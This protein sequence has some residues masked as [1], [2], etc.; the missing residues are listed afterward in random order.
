MKSDVATFIVTALVKQ[1]AAEG[2]HAD[3]MAQ[4]VASLGLDSLDFMELLNEIEEEFEVR[5][6]DDT[7]AASTTVA[8]LIAFIEGNV[9]ARRAM[10]PTDRT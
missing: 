5:I 7:V 1:G 2:C 9:A 3:L 8:E 4:T 10:H 6:E